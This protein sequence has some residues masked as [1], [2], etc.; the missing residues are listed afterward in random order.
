MAQLVHT[1]QSSNRRLGLN[2]YTN[3]PIPSPLDF[4]SLAI[5]IRADVGC[6]TDAAKTIPCVNNDAVYTWADQKGGYDFIQSTLANRPSYRAGVV[7]GLP[8][9]MF[10]ATN[11]SCTLKA[12]QASIGQPYTICWVGQ[13]IDTLPGPNYCMWFNGDDNGPQVTWSHGDTRSS[14]GP[15]MY[16]VT[17]APRNF[18]PSYPFFDSF[19]FATT[20]WNGASSLGRVMTLGGTCESSPGTGACRNLHLMNDPSNSQCALHGYMAELCL[21][22]E[23]FNA[24]SINKIET[25]FKNKYNL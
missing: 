23:A 9:L 7:N 22:T 19:F 16:N 21:F 20:V 18:W 8:A 6:Y 24:A 14:A 2:E 4:S 12:T 1:L 5:W 25:Y 3:T 13:A 10:N 17:G 11:N 15:W